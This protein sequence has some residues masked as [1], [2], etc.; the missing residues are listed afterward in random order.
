[1]RHIIITG[2][3]RGIGKELA[4]AAA[5]RD[6]G[7]HLIARSPMTD[8][9]ESIR[10]KGASVW[11]YKFNL[12]ETEKLEKLMDAI[13]NHIDPGTDS[14]VLINNAGMLAPI[15]P[16]GKYDTEAFRLNLE[17]NYVSPLLLTHIFAN[18]TSNYTGER[19]VVMMTSGAAEHPLAGVSHYCSAKAGMNQFLR[20]MMAEQKFASN[21][22]RGLAFNPGKT[23]TSMQDEIRRA[24]LTDFRY[25]PEFVR[26]K[27]EGELRNPAVI[28]GKLINLISKGSYE[29]GVVVNVSDI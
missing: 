4:M 22:I 13:L 16:V 2:A 11:S 19:C 27:Q 23:D 14:T 10:E 8:L 12:A 25:L 6:T 1:M 29:D 20:T 28:A 7:L 5:G 9:V 3:S 24:S 18:R 17:L 26:A 21:P 15:G